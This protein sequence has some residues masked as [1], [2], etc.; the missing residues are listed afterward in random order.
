MADKVLVTGGAGFIGSH[1]VDLLLE[2]GYSVRILDNLELPTHLKGKAAYIPKEAEFIEGNMV[3][4]KVIGRALKDV[5]VVIHQAA[6]GGFTGNIEK[7]YY[8][9]TLGLARILEHVRGKRLSLKKIVVASSIAVYGEGKYHCL[10]H[11][12]Q[13][14]PIRPLEQLN[15][16]EWEVKCPICQDE[17]K[18]LATDEDKPVS[19]ESHYAITKY[20]TERMALVFGKMHDIP[21]V[22]LRYFVTY[23]PRQSIFNPYTGICS[24]FSMRILNNKSPVIYE[25][26]LQTRDF[27]YVKDVARANLLVLENEKVNHQAL[28]VG[29]SKPITVKEIAVTLMKKYKKDLPLTTGS[30]FRPQDVRHIVADISRI[31][32]LDFRIQYSFS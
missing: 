7:Y 3:D 29:T 18:P 20:D 28:N 10:N 27:V 22:A 2:N 12:V 11:G 24:I 15:R 4:E 16:K 1:I 31:K 6:T 14:P 9:N 26:G 23:G 19:P 25:D 8:N 17:M 21:T 13:Y 30:Q 32:Q 5:Q